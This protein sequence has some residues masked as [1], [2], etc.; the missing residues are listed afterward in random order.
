MRNSTSS[1]ALLP[2]AIMLLLI[3]FLPLIS[4]DLISETCDQ[5]PNDRLCVTVLRRDNRSHGADVSGLAM[6]IIEAVRDEANSTLESIKEL[7]K[8]NITLANALMECQENYNVIMRIDIPKAIG[9]LRDNPR[10]A[11]HGMADAGIEAQG[12][13]GS[14]GEQVESPLT[15][16]NSLVNDLSVIALSIIRIMLHR[17]Y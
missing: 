15:D 11:E 3:I 2:N 16:M 10:F 4:C 12:C 7:K 13:E 14:L 5:T 1:N 17:F 6:I 9:S 8:S